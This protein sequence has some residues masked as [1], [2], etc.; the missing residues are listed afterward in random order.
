M[1]SGTLTMN[2]VSDHDLLIVLEVKLKHEGK[3]IFNPQQMQ[4]GVQGNPPVSTYNNVVLS[5]NGSTGLN[6]LIEILRRLHPEET[7]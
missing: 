1:T 7:Q 3:L 2:G 6:A 4:A 5:W